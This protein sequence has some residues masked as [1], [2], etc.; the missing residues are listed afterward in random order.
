[1]SD[2][3]GAAGA[4]VENAE[5]ELLLVKEGKQHIEDSWNFPGGG[6]EDGES[7]TDCVK[8]EV[9]EE[10]GY[11]IS[12]EGFLGVYKELNQEDGTET[13]VFMF[14]ALTDEKVKEAPQDSD[15]IKDTGFFRPEKIPD[16]ELRHENRLD[17]LERYEKGKEIPVE[18]LWKDLEVL[19]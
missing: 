17:I 11:R 2:F 5:G 9:L 19:N 4:V 1:M 14:K 12:I 8:R 10:T 16:L 3:Y 7:I 13:I 18:A 15:E 6:W